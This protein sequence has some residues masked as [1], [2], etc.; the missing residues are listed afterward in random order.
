MIT[1]MHGAGGRLMIEFI[2][3]Q[4]LKNI[5]LKKV[6][7]L[8]LD[9]LDDAGTIKLDDKHIAFTTDSYT[10][11]PIFFP[12]G[13][14]GRL[15]V[16]GTVNDL[17]VVGAKP[18]ALSLAFIIPE[19]Y[20]EEKIERIIKSIN[21]TSKEAEV[22]IIAG[23]TKVTD[24]LDEIII[25]TSGVGVAEKVIK[26][27]GVKDG[28]A[29]IVSGNIAEHGLAILLSREEF[30]FETNIKSD[31]AP[32]NKMIE[33][34][35]DLEISAMKDPTRGG[36]AE[37]LN[38]L[39][40]KSSVGITIFED[41]IPISDEVS[42]V[43]EILGL[44]PLTIANEGKVVIAVD[45]KDAEECLERLREHPLGKNAEIIGYAT[46]EHKGVLMETGIGKRIIDYPIGDPIPR[47]C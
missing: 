5:E 41:K 42:S 10:V 24:G 45:K 19:G 23:D 11:K 38:E 2:K 43:C 22:A 17:S 39:A 6:N 9:D 1:K 34:I 31:V 16:S 15:A 46:K 30:E 8:G 25:N 28:D 44:D 40:E 33:N 4:I 32:L 29:I 36:L 13:D 37:A 26:D 3:N 12:G 14:I 27:S 21:K 7:G 18:L 20:D 47:V 35:L